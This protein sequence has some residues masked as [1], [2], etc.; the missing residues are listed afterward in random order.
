MSQRSAYL[1]LSRDSRA[2]LRFG[3]ETLFVNASIMDTYYEPRNPPW[4]IDLDL[5]R[6]LDCAVEDPTEAASE[7][8]EP[9][10]PLEA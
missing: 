1:D 10:R 8:I 6:D 3:E 4:L 5:P 9:G 2:A 7:A